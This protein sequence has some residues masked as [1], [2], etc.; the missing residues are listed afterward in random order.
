VLIGAPPP[1][2][3]VRINALD[4]V[5]CQRRILGCLTGN[6]RPD[7]DFDR[8]FRLYRRG[9]LALDR[10]VT[11]RLPLSQIAD[12]FRKTHQREGIR[13]IIRIGEE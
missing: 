2:A 5:N 10:L 4:I 1:R 6:V 11:A 7:I 12:A 3:E 8:Y 13:T 9:L